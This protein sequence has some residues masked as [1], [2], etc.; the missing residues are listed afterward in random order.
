MSDTTINI[1]GTS[2]NSNLVLG[3]AGGS[4]N[5]TDSVPVVPDT[6]PVNGKK[7]YSTS[8][9]TWVEDDKTSQLTLLDYT[10]SDYMLWNTSTPENILYRPALV[11]T[12]EIGDYVNYSLLQMDN[13]LPESRKE[14]HLTRIKTQ[15]NSIVAAAKAD[16][17]VSFKYHIE[18]IVLVSSAADSSKCDIYLGIISKQKLSDALITDISNLGVSGEEVDFVF[19]IRNSNSSMVYALANGPYGG[20]VTA[21]NDLSLAFM[22][23]TYIL[24]KSDAKELKF[25]ETVCT[26]GGLL[27]MSHNFVNA[28][29]IQTRD[30]P[31]PKTNNVDFVGTYHEFTKDGVD[32]CCYSCLCLYTT[33]DIVANLTAHVLPASPTSVLEVKNLGSLASNLRSDI[34][35]YTYLFSVWFGAKSLKAPKESGIDIFGGMTI[36]LDLN[37]Y[38][39]IDNSGLYVTQELKTAWTNYALKNPTPSLLSYVKS[40]KDNFGVNGM[41]DMFFKELTVGELVPYQVLCFLQT[42]TSEFDIPITGDLTL[43]SGVNTTKAKLISNGFATAS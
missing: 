5:S 41:I 7:V 39:L 23:Y 24:K 9:K 4:I 29:A 18:K 17:S 1:G 43:V 36:Y 10:L 11:E 3:S 14:E 40:I 42:A 15:W 19:S 31:R 25:Y 28:P 32:Y 35:S 12:A 6:T 33:K 38:T 30:G 20:A 16:V 8:T 34:Y 2:N 27:L 13:T 22:P 37:S 21:V 26:H